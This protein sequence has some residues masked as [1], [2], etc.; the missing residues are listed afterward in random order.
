MA[1]CGDKSK[2]FKF[3]ERNSGTKTLSGHAQDY[4]VL[5][6]TCLQKKAL[7]EDPEFPCN[8]SNVY[9]S[10]TPEEK[11]LWK[12]PRELCEN[13]QFIKDGFS[14][15][16]VKQG[17]LGNCWMVAST[18][19]LA[20]HK[21]L[22]ARVVPEPQ[23]FDEDKYAGI[24][25]FRLW[26]DNRWVDV[27]VDD[28]LPVNED[29]ELLFMC[30]RTKDEFWSALLEK[31]FAKL[32]GGYAALEGGSGVEAMLTF[33][34]GL[35]EQI[36]LSEPHKD[37][38]KTLQKAF[39]RSSLLTCSILEEEKGGKGLSVLHEYSLTGVNKVTLP[40][41]G[42]IELVRLRNPW[43][44]SEWKGPWGDTSKKWKQVSE[45]KKQELGLVVK[46][47]GEFWM[48]MEDFLKHFQLL[49]I[50]H[51]GPDTLSSH[52][53][54]ESASKRWEMST[55]EG[56]WVP[57][58][59]AGGGP[60]D[61]EKFATNP[62]YLITLE[63]PDDDNEDGECTVIVALLQKNRRVFEAKEGMFHSIGFALFEVEDPCSCPVPLT[64][65]YLEDNTK[66]AEVEEFQASREVTKRFLLLP[67]NFCVIPATE[68]PDL[69][70]EFLLRIYT[71]KKSISKEHDETPGIIEKPPAILDVCPIDKEDDGAEPTENEN[72]VDGG[73]ENK[74]EE[75]EEIDE[76]L[77][78]MFNE[79][80]GDEGKVC[81]ESLQTLLKK[82]F[83]RDGN[84]QE[85]SLDICRSMVALI[86]DSYTGQLSVEGFAV[87]YK[88]IKEWE[89][90]FKESDKDCTG[91]L[92]TYQLRNA[93]RNAGYSVNQ[94]VLKGLVLRYG[95]DR[96][97]GFQD[98]IGCAV[99]LMCMISIFDEWDED[100]ENCVM[101]T[102]NEWLK[103]TMYC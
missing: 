43:G 71:E 69:A 3:G 96:K 66:V 17:E 45:E 64:Q 79:V 86:D 44:S 61:M 10:K 9:G 21:D 65:E 54:G 2:T 62:Q 19:I 1:H 73:E 99:K 59:N 75:E 74:E 97:I 82:V 78:R 80:A 15:F 70:G 36:D 4:D 81:C 50:C 89:V 93:L 40:D 42:T 32:H 100:K 5:F 16:D 12:R 47:D 67:G 13:P 51:L 60:S 98:F 11:L 25:H 6:E 39:E 28:R 37:F 92:S 41:V 49:D 31:A 56:A 38:Y 18:A 63:E 26:Q 34:G 68:E 20:M 35:S 94:H 55:F 58:S 24:F 84:P 8:V 46:S 7:F 23:N 91:H 14:R 85:F 52:T 88:N 27:P 72:E 83:E 77:K 102:R 76:D 53:T 95:H 101:V 48:S 90:A 87:L 33:T 22:L 29:G 30:S 103:V 57:G